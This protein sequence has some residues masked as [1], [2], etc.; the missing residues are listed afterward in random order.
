M[1]CVILSYS[2]IRSEN[3]FKENLIFKSLIM[4]SSQSD[5]D[6]CKPVTDR[7]KWSK[8]DVF[9][10][11]LSSFPASVREFDSLNEEDHAANLQLAFDISEREFGIRSFTS[12]KELSAGEEL[13]K[14]RMIAYLSKFYELFRGTPLPASGSLTLLG[15][16]ALDSILLYSSVLHYI[17]LHSVVY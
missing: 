11:N 15:S 17:L 3:M 13:D 16:T 5:W 10:L 6:K 2:T 9:S 1:I 12:A 14:T 7:G 8:T 4:H